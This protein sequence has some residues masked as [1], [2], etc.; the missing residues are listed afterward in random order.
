MS[1]ATGAETTSVQ[2]R[3][4]S[5]HQE[6]LLS[7]D[8]RGPSG[9]TGERRRIIVGL[10]LLCSDLISAFL[11]LSLVDSVYG[12]PWTEMTFTALPVLIGIFWGSGLYS[13]YWLAPA[14]RLRARLLGTLAFVATS[15]VVSGEAFHLAIWFA[16]AC[17]G[18]LIFL[19]GYYAEALT[20][21]AL[22]RRKLWGAATA[23]AGGGAAIEQ[24]QRLLSAIPELGLRP[25]DRVGLG[26]DPAGLDSAE[27]EFVVAAS[28]AEFNTHF[29]CDEVCRF[30][31]SGPAAS[32][33]R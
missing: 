10:T 8:T 12:F 27:I 7:R 29:E 24:A 19:L 28:K 9:L 20:R 1:I 22:I 32:G 31:A 16:A 6:L 18:A 30:F 23:F 15:I 11:A 2:A 4:R 26:E 25:V 33:R 13:S 21:H 5:S 3:D 14:E 17:Q